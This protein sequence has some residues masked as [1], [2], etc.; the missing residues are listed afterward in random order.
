MCQVDATFIIKTLYPYR[1][2]LERTRDFWCSPRMRQSR[3]KPLNVMSLNVY[4]K[5]LKILEI[6]FKQKLNVD[7]VIGHHP[8]LRIKN[9]LA[10]GY[11]GGLAVTNQQLVPD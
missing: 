9:N 4:T 7:Q 1:E 11:Q 5:N 10:V 6:I 2:P 8:I 3:V